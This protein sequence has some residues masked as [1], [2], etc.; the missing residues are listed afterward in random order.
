MKNPKT[1]VKAL[2]ANVIARRYFRRGNL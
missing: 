1:G 2:Y